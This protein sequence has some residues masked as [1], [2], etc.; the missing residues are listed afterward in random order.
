MHGGIVRIQ[1]SPTVDTVVVVLVQLQAV[2]Y[3]S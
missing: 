3:K 1:G 2:A